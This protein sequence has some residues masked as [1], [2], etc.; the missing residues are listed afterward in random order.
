MTWK[1]LLEKIRTGLHESGAYLRQVSHA[2]AL[3]SEDGN[4]LS[5]IEVNAMFASISLAMSNLHSAVAHLAIGV[6]T[7][8]KIVREGM[9]TQEVDSE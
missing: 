1:E 4:N 6:D 3:V 5:S 8:A 9:N 2:V 7:I